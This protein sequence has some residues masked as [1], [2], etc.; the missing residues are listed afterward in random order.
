MEHKSNMN[1]DF[2]DF[3][4]NRIFEVI[5]S[6]QTIKGA[7]NNFFRTE[8][9]EKAIA[10]HSGGQLAYVHEIGYDFT[11]VDEVRYESKGQN[12]VWNAD[13]NQRSSGIVIKNT[14]PSKKIGQDTKEQT[15]DYIFIWETGHR[16]SLYI[17]TWEQCKNNIVRNSS[18]FTL[19][20]LNKKD[21]YCVVDNYDRNS[22]TITDMNIT[23]DRFIESLI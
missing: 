4:L 23:F 14:M 21:L 16:L 18:G 9:Q 1:L 5:V 13:G 19:Q 22:L 8:I 11:D 10:K 6:S 15:F 20:E 7:Q 2:A 17:A 3:N 12:V